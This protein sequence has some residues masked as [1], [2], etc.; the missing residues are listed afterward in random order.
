MPA[1]NVEA[2][3]VAEVEG[4]ESEAQIGKFARILAPLQ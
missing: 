1:I 2:A 3:G 4:D